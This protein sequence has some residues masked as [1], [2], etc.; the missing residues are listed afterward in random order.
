MRSISFHTTGPYLLSASEDRSIRV[1]DLRTARCVHSVSE[2]H[3]HFV[4]SLAMHSK[5]PL[6]V[7]GSVDTA[8][9]VWEC[10]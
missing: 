10:S 2:A 5:L 1:W 4:T 8:V 7:T 3:K 6:V 9:N